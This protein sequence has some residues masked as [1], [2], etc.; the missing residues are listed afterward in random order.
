MASLLINNGVPLT[1][2]SDYLGHAD[3]KVT[4]NTYGHLDKAS[5]SVSANV[6]N[7]VLNEN[8]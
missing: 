2:V 4:A 8:L 3:I 1:H 5:K 7:S 6:I